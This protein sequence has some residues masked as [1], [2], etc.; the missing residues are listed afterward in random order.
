MGYMWIV[1]TPI[2]TNLCIYVSL[3]VKPCFIRIE[4][5]LWIDLTKRQAV[6]TNCKN[7]PCQLD[8]TAARHGLLFYRV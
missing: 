5:L 2:V 1:L 6:E 3:Q 7:E 8:H 4:C